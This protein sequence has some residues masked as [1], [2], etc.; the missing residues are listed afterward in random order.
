MEARVVTVA[1]AVISYSG[2]ARLAMAVRVAQASAMDPP[3]RAALPVMVAERAA[4]A[5]LAVLAPAL[6][7]ATEAKAAMARLPSS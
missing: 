2:A 1:T 7:A 3:E 6:P 5:V 4:T